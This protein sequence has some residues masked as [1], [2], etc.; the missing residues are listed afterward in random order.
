MNVFSVM[1]AVSMH[2][3]ANLMPHLVTVDLADCHMMRRASFV[4]T[5]VLVQLMAYAHRV[6]NVL[7]AHSSTL[8]NKPLRC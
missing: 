4:Y 6:S 8:S 7:V 5:Q 2:R 1:G 3:R